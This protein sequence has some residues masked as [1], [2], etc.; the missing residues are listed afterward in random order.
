MIAR[1]RAG[2][3]WLS[4]GVALVLSSGA[5]DDAL[6]YGL[7][8][9]LGTEAG[10]ERA[11]WLAVMLAQ[12]L[13]RFWLPLQWV[14]GGA[15]LLALLTALPLVWRALRPRPTVFISYHHRRE[16]QAAAVEAALA[17]EGLHPRRVPFE[18]GATHQQVV[19]RMQQL[20]STCL[21][22]ER[23]PHQAMN[24]REKPVYEGPPAP[25]QDPPPIRN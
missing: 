9:L 7:K 12:S 11:A 6:L 16:A 18:P 13:Q 20:R 24:G 17:A 15:T 23:S 22:R 1:L 25:P 4:G 5:F 21:D 8:L 2:L 10:R 3:L 19:G 14:L